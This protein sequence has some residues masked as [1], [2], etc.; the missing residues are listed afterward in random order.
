MEPTRLA[1][2]KRLLLVTCAVSALLV[3]LAAQCPGLSVDNAV[4]AALLLSAGTL[5]VLCASVLLEDTL[6]HPLL[7]RL[8]AF[9]ARRPLLTQ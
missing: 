6:V 9:R 8:R 1:N 4:R 2:S 3:F 7:H 5:A